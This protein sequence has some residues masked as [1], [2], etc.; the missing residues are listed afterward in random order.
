MQFISTEVQ[1]VHFKSFISL[2][3]QTARRVIQVGRIQVIFLRTPGHG[4]F[5]KQTTSFL[6]LPNHTRTITSHI[7]HY[8]KTLINDAKRC[9][10]LYSVL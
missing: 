6:Y 2:I 9:V 1:S 3:H 7:Q 4:M 8:T 10:W 5:L